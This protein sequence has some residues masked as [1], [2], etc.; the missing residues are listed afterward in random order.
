MAADPA[1]VLIVGA[2]PTG[3]TLAAGLAASGARFRIIDRLVDRTHESRALAIQPRTLE[4][5]AGLGIADQL[6]ER[7]N[8]GMEVQMHSRGRTTQLP[9]FDIGLEDTAYPFLLFLSQADTEAVLDDHL[10]SQARRVERGVELIDLDETTD[11]VTC[12]LH[13]GPHDSEQIHASYVVGCDGADSTVR[14]HAS[15]DFAGDAY[16]QAFVLADLAADGL[17]HA[18]VHVHLTRTGMLFFFPLGHPAPWRLLAMRPHTT[19]PT[20]ATPSLH[21]LQALADTYTDGSVALHDPVWATNF[22]LQHRHARRYRTNR[23]FLAGDAAHIHSPAG[24]QGMN[25]GIQ[26]AWNLAWKLAWVTGGTALPTLLDTYETERRPV[27]RDVLRL[28]DRAFRIATSTNPLVGLI[29]TRLAPRLMRL[30]LA[31]PATRARAFRGLSQLTINYRTSPFSHHGH[32]RLRRGP[33]P[34]DRLPDAPISIDNRATTL[35]R[36]LD[37]SHLHLL[38]TGTP[39]DPHHPIHRIPHIRTHHLTNQPAAHAL[40]DTTGQAHQRL[41]LQPDQTTRHL[42]RPDGHIAYRAAGDDLDGLLQH[43]HHWLTTPSRAKR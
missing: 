4:V 1:D 22:R 11:A 40:V 13:R 25:T 7:G 32:S 26:D 42:I 5:L 29:R 10:A 36:A 41:G 17:D 28:T 43:L 37:P 30:A 38:T 18:A 31:T 3:L 20:T 35:H 34:G 39:P 27:G 24:A 2:G 33:Q 23:V 15:I 16:P 14:R 9:L 19:P 8:P 21:E 12:T 6:V